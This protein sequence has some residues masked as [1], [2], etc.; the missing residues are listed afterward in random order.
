MEQLI[1]IDENLFEMINSGWSNT[2]FDMLLPF[3]RKKENWFPIYGIIAVLLIYKYKWQGLLFVAIASLTVVA[4]DQISSSVIKP[5]FQRLR[6]CNNQVVFDQINV[7]TKCGS[8][9]SFVSSHATNHFG[10]AMIM[11][12]MLN[13]KFKWIFPVGILWAGLISLAQIYCGVHYP[14]DVIS[15][16]ILGVLLAYLVF[17]I[18]KYASRKLFKNESLL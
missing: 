15:G 7:L 18:G 8:G 4:T 2:F 11:T 12:F 13:S 3:M 10:F 6:P 17:V 14:F 16:A 5:L 1:Q 9:F